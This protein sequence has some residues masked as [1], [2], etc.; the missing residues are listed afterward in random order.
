MTDDSTLRRELNRRLWERL[1]VDLKWT[2]KVGYAL[3]ML[4]LVL[5]VHVQIE[6]H[7]EIIAA[8]CQTK[9]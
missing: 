2:A 5:G 6:R 1:K 7:L 4:V 9:L 8:A 3:G